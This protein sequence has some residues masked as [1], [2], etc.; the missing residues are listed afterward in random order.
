MTIQVD[1]GAL[2]SAF[3]E[4]AS[5]WSRLQ[6]QFEDLQA[7]VARLSGSW[8]GAAQEA[9]RRSQRAWDLTALDLHEAL[10]SMGSGIQQANSNFRST[11][12]V[13]TRGWA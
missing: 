3:G 10:H 2:E 6:A 11:E 7:C 1:H 8:D 4:V 12:N 9:Y 5:S 13:N